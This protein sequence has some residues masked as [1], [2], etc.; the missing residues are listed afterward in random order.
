M[1]LKIIQKQLQ[2]HLSQRQALQ[3]RITADQRDLDAVEGA[4]QALE[5]LVK[6]EQE[7]LAK[8]CKEKNLWRLQQKLRI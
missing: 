7:R 3:D 8:T 4:I 1:R 2:E 6:K 5:L